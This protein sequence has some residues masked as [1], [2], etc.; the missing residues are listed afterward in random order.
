MTLV[1]NHHVG[2]RFDAGTGPARAQAG[3][4][5]GER[6]R[7]KDAISLLE[8]AREEIGMH[9]ADKAEA[10]AF[11][12][13]GIDGA[14]RVRRMQIEQIQA[15]LDATRRFKD[16]AV[17]ADLVKRMQ[18]SPRPQDVAHGAAREPAQRHALL[19]LAL[20]DA[21]TR[22]LPPEVLEQ[23]EDALE[24]LEHEAGPQIA[25]GL[26]TAQAAAEFAPTA[27]GV[28]NF[29]RAY[30]DI[31]LGESSFAQTLLV[32]L[33]RLAG[34]E[35]EDFARG[36]QALLNALGADLQ[37]VRPSADPAR[38]RALVSDIYQIE[39]AG[40]VLEGCTQLSQS[41][42]RSFGIGGVV[43]ME[44]MQE[45]VTLTGER[46]VSTQRLR[47]LAE[48]FRIEMLKARIA[49]HTGNKGLLRKMPV[50]VFVDG[51]ARLA[52]LGCVQTLLDEEVAE[53]EEGYGP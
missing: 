10:K 6:V 9:H 5:A 22:G 51:D 45:L 24:E 21:H 47:A 29:Q 50:K 28:Q 53:E 31:V 41:I 11:R 30:A 49:F 48:R 34:A 8:D 33:R 7:V 46:W 40:T 38:L 44:L 17:L 39:V 25:A 32:V 43:P 26:N 16:P 27:E 37:A 1:D 19:Q 15:Y 12:E 13:R 4:L 42:A 23:L 14:A 20:D 36:L 35:G 2:G 18:S 52:L 3:L